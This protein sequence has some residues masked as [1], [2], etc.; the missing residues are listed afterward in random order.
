MTHYLEN[1]LACGEKM[2]STRCSFCGFA[3]QRSEFTG[4]LPWYAEGMWYA[5][6][7]S[8]P[9]IH[10]PDGTLLVVQWERV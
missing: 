9:W 6:D 10:V 2:Y 4:G 8:K 5:V 7:G 1:C 3:C